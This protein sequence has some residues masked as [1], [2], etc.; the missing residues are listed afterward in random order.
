MRIT[1]HS[2]IGRTERLSSRGARATLIVA[3]ALGAILATGMGSGGGGFVVDSHGFGAG[4]ESSSASFSVVATIGAPLAGSSDSR[5]YSVS[6]G[7][8][9]VVAPGTPPCPADFDGDRQVDGAD[10]GELLGQWGACARCPAD[11]NGDD[12]V[13]GDD[14]GGLLGAWGPCP[15]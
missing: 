9:A 2:S 15:V 1:P 11:F 13:D 12:Q 14:L 8:I 3:T 10:L 5:T 7:F 4:G 6:G